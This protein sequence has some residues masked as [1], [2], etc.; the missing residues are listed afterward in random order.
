[1]ADGWNVNTEMQRID[2]MSFPQGLDG[3]DK[4]MQLYSNIYAFLQNIYV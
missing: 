1:M 4:Y 3:I 2:I